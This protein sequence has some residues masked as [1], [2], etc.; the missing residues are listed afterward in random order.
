MS[1]DEERAKHK[2]R[3]SKQRSVIARALE[4][5]QFRQKKIPANRKEDEDEKQ[6]R[7]YGVRGIED[8]N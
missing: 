3:R 2:Q 1:T 6:F 4:L 7:K 5:K 8:D